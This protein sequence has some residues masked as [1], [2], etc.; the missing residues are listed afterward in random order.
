MYQVIVTYSEN[1]PWWFFDEWQEDIQTE[2]AFD[3]FCSA[4]KRFDQLA[5]EYQSEFELDKIKPPLLAAFWNDGDL[6]Y[7]EDC[8]EEL[9]AYKGLLL[10]KDYQKLDDGD[11]ENNEAIN[12]SGK[13]KCCTRHS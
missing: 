7:C 1:E 12:N 13:T 11:L 2:E 9:Q 6:I 8:D 5:T 4:K 10:V 3:C